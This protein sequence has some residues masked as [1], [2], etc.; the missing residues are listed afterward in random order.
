MN[1]LK[2]CRHFEKHTVVLAKAG[3]QEIYC[4]RDVGL[5][6]YS[7]DSAFAGMTVNVNKL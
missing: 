1:G 4:N 2:P 6:V 7:L 3:T 5:V